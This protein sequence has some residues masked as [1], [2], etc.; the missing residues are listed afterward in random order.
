MDTL[1]G[2]CSTNL[3]FY[4]FE[5]QCKKNL[6]MLIILEIPASRLFP[7]VD[8]QLPLYYVLSHHLNCIYIYSL[9]LCSWDWTYKSLSF[10]LAIIN[11][12]GQSRL[13]TILILLPYFSNYL[14]W[15][16]SQSPFFP[17]EP[18]FWWEKWTLTLFSK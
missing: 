3:W 14:F 11:C 18:M 1:R 13:G 7:G 6:F 2:K 5:W 17:P 15:S 10:I 12:K 9:A 8:E 4:A 16:Q